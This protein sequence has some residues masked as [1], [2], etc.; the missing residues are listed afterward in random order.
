[1][2]TKA[3][4]SGEITEVYSDSYFKQSYKD[5]QSSLSRIDTTDAGRE[6]VNAGQQVSP[7]Y[8]L[9]SDITARDVTEY[10]I[11]GYWYFDKRQSELKYRLLGI[12]PVTQMFIP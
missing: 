12:C 4:K 3:V 2:L 11:K 10:K 9:R 5:I 8:I 7:E 6:Q 1:V